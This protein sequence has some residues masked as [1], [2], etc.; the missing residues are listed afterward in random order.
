MK[1]AALISDIHSNL[2]ALTAVLEHIER[3][4]YEEIYCLGDVVGYGPD[5]ATCADLVRKHC[6]LTLM[7]NHDEAV[8]K[9][10]WSFNEVARTAIDW[11]RKQL[12]PTLLRPGSRQRWKFLQ[13][14]P[15]R[16]EWGNWSL[17]HGSPRDP[18]SEY[19][20][21]RD[22]QW[23]GAAKFDELFQ[24]VDSICFVGHTHIPGIFTTEPVFTPQ[25]N[26]D[27]AFSP[28]PDDGKWI[29]N[30]GSVGQPRDGDRR[31][32]YLGYSEGKFR[33]HRVEYPYRETQAKIRGISLL[34]DRL[35][36]R[37]GEGC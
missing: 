7:G 37:L 16:H 21:P 13:E 31:A 10:A 3:T 15:L 26:V 2:E 25:K 27:E 22:A 30:V 28:G 17:V 1:S 23:P 12:R 20:L 33:F 34:D 36:D 14:L 9:G 18:T 6:K 24:S 4:G 29:V 5:P 11:T 8:F 35:A 32:C 19:I